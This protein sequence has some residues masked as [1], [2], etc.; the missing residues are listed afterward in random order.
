[1]DL[2]V[3]V[4]HNY[5]TA[6]IPSQ[7]I[8]INNKLQEHDPY[9]FIDLIVSPFEA[10]AIF[11]FDPMHMREPVLL[12]TILD[13]RGNFRLP[14]DRDVLEMRMGDLRTNSELTYENYD[15]ARKRTEAK[16][17]EEFREFEKEFAKDLARAAHHDGIAHAPRVSM[18]VSKREKKQK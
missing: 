5:G 15:K 4:H 2:S 6:Y 16:R 8:D 13:D 12:R 9:L 17:E 1:M 11:R 14:D 10:F 18:H 3:P 7:V